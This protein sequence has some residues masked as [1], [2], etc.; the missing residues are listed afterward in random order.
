MP[1]TFSVDGERPYTTA[2][3]KPKKSLNSLS[4][5]PATASTKY[6]PG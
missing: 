4:I 1:Y 5:Q 3:A 6:R 2:E